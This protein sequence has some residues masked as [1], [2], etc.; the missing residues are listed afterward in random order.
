MVL[1]L[2]FANLR[3]VMAD[4]HCS[5]GANEWALLPAHDVVKRLLDYSLTHIE[6]MNKQPHLITSVRLQPSQHI[7]H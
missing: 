2:P 5:M 3:T 4:F 1:A 7:S 6:G